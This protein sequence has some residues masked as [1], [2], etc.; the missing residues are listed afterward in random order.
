MQAL[1]TTAAAQKRAYRKASIDRWKA[2]RA[3]QTSSL[4]H[5]HYPF[6]REAASGRKRMNGKFARERQVFVSMKELEAKV[7][8][9]QAA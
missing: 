3:R 7:A 9:V 6:R 5:T 1:E 2:K 4:K 8:G